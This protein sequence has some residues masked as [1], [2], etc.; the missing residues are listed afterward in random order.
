MASTGFK[1]TR[2]ARREFHQV[3]SDAGIERG[4]RE[5]V[6]EDCEIYLSRDRPERLEKPSPSPRTQLTRIR[7]HAEALE[8]ALRTTSHDVWISLEVEFNPR[9]TMPKA[10]VKK[11][12]GQVVIALESRERLPG[13]VLLYELLEK[14]LELSKATGECLKRI[15]P[16]KRGPRPNFKRW[17]VAL[18]VAAAFVVNGVP[19]KTSRHGPLERCTAIALREAHLGLPKDLTT[20][21]R[22][23]GPALLIR[24]VVAGMKRVSSRLK[25]G[26]L[27]LQRPKRYK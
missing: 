8:K 6:I 25:P 11:Q 21:D 19:V 16:R 12:D 24:E 10:T 18:S 3:L 13:E 2:A 17:S 27:A 20:P 9:L 26:S 5:N 14:I 23:A 4:V 15:R 22:F 1:F 7:R